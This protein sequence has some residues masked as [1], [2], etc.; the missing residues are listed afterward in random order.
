VPAKGKNFSVRIVGE[1]SD[2]LGI[3]SLGFVFKLGKVKEK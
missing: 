2:F 1:S 3:E